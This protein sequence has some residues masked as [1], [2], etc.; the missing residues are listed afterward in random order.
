MRR[1]WGMLRYFTRVLLSTNP[2][3]EKSAGGVVYQKD[4]NKVLWLVIQNSSTK[5]WTFPKGLIGDHR[6]EKLE[7][8]ALREVKEE[9]GVTAKIIHHK[10]V[11]SFYTYKVLG[12]LV[13]KTVYYFL[14]EYVSGSPGDH[15][16]EVSESKFVDEKEVFELLSFDQDKAAFKNALLLYKSSGDS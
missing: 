4:R 16:W 12:V 13:K 5:K 2:R 15:D 1:T 6:E 14:M 8:A 11:E 10:P 7:T 3:I 9:G